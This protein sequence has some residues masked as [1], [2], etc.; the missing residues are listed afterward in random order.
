[1]GLSFNNSIGN[2]GITV[3]QSNN[4]RFSDASFND[5]SGGNLIIT[6]ARYTITEIIKKGDNT[7]LDTTSVDLSN[8]AL[9]NLT[10]TSFDIIIVKSIL[11]CNSLNIPKRR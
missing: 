9:S 10:P 2:T 4:S 1:M 8:L 5:V 3:T 11:G 7:L 6:P